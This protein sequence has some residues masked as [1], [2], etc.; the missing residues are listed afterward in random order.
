MISESSA[1]SK[2]C[3][4]ELKLQVKIVITNPL[5]LVILLGAL[6]CLVPWKIHRHSVEV[7]TDV[8]YES[9]L[10]DG[11]PS[12]NIS[13]GRDPYTVFT[14][15]LVSHIVSGLLP[16]SYRRLHSTTLMM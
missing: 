15:F 4:V 6:N 1:I 9:G 11:F 7:R 2:P 12:M 10:V 14:S 8:K 5:P 3:G 13:P 16:C